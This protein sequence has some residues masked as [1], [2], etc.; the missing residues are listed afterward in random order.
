VESDEIVAAAEGWGVGVEYI[1][2]DDEG[3]GFTKKKFC[4]RLNP[5]PILKSKY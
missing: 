2:F 5:Y 1:V 4:W 3:D